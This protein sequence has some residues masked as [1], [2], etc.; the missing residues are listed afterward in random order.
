MVGG[1][2]RKSRRNRSACTAHTSHDSDS[3]PPTKVALRKHII[4]THFPKDR[5]S[6]FGNQKRQ[7]LLAED[8]LAK[9]YLEQKSLVT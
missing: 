7:G 4:V 9:Q 2:H 8:A 5:R 6:M 1:V 3:G